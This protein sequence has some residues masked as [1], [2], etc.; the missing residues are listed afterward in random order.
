MWPEPFNFI[1]VCSIRGDV[2]LAV[3]HC[4]M[5]VSHISQLVIHSGLIRVNTGSLEDM[6]L[7][8]WNE[9]NGT[10][11]GNSEHENFF[12]GSIDATKHPW[13]TF[14]PHMVTPVLLP[15]PGDP[16]L[17]KRICGFDSRLLLGPVIPKTFKN[18]SGLFLHGTRDEGGTAKHNWSAWCQYNVT[19]W[20]SMWT[21]DMLSQWGSTIKR[22]LSP[23]ATNRNLIS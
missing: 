9:G 19:G 15:S 2:G 6:C 22:A 3:V 17:T 14:I 11:V 5:V 10:L 21:Y 4:V 8:Q 20:V 16:A 13:T 1:C 12:R 18:G 7:N 23:T